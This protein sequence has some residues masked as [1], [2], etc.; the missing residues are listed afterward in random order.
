MNRAELIDEI[1]KRLDSTKKDA[2]RAVDAVVD[3]IQRSINEGDKVRVKGLGVFEAAVEHAVLAFAGAGRDPEEEG[4]RARRRRDERQLPHGRER[5]EL[6][7]EILEPRR[8]TS[9]QIDCRMV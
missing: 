5:R 7:Q 1:A 2:E 9:P 6:L 3:V 4:E 8:Q